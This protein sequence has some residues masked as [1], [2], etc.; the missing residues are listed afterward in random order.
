MKGDPDLETVRGCMS[1]D[2]AI[3]EASFTQ[4]F[5][6][7][8]DKVYATALRITGDATLAHDAAQ[9]TFL[10]V[11]EKIGTFHFK[12]RF[13][14]WLYRI[15]VNFSIDRTR[16]ASKEPPVVSEDPGEG[17]SHR[18]HRSGED[19]QSVDP[20]KIACTKEF[21]ARIQE[22]IARLSEPLRVVVVLRFMN[23]LTYEEI[24]EVVGCPVGTVKSR[25]NRG[26]S[27]LEPLLEPILG[28]ESG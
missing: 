12:A 8:E 19:P 18:P 28:Q 9:E 26:L 25:L 21:E 4:L 14:S 22:V 23:G 17:S 15:A 16:K 2:P 20:E 10:A 27:A 1:E 13:S 3:R 11:F 7:Y 6:K 5:E 24:G